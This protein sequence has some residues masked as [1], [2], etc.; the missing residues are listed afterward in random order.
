MVVHWLEK[1][2]SVDVDCGRMKPAGIETIG[3]ELA[4]KWDDG[5]ESYIPL[6]ILR[7]ECPCAGCKG[8]TDITG[9]VHRGPEVKLGPASFALKRIVN[10]G[11][12]GITPVWAD[13]HAT[14]IYTFEYLRRLSSQDRKSTRL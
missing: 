13:G 3:Q 6:E 4:I 1:Q 5:S 11:G 8:E 2:C 12:Y 14:G 10:V 7:R 9:Q